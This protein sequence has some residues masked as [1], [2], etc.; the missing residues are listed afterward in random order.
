MLMPILSA[1][2]CVFKVGHRF[3]SFILS[4]WY[5]SVHI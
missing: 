1:I 2:V 5:N 4:L 3:S